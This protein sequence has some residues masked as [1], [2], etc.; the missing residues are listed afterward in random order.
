MTVEISSSPK[1]KYTNPIKNLPHPRTKHAQEENTTHNPLKQLTPLPEEN[2]DIIWN[3]VSFMFASERTALD[4]LAHK[5]TKPMGP[6]PHC[7]KCGAPTVMDGGPG[8]NRCQ[9]HPSSKQF[10]CQKCQ[11]KSSFTSTLEGRVALALLAVRDLII[12][13]WNPLT[14]RT[15]LSWAAQHVTGALA[16]P[17]TQP[18]AIIHID[19]SHRGGNVVIGLVAPDELP[20]FLIARSENSDDVTTLLRSVV[21]SK[22]DDLVVVSDGGNAIRKAVR[23]ALP[24]CVH[25]RQFHGEWRGLVAV[26]WMYEGDP[27]TLFVPWDL[28]SKEKTGMSE[29]KA[30]AAGGLLLFHGDIVY[31]SDATRM[32]GETPAHTLILT[33]AI[34]YASELLHGLSGVAEA[35]DNLAREGSNSSVFVRMFNLVVRL[36]RLLPRDERGVVL[37]LLCMVL[38]RIGEGVRPSLRR[39]GRK[40]RRAIENAGFLGGGP[41]FREAVGRAVSSL[42][43]PNLEEMRKREE[44]NRKPVSDGKRRKTPAL[45]KDKRFLLAKGSLE[46][47]ETRF[48]ELMEAPVKA[49]ETFRSLVITNNRMENLWSHLGGTRGYNL[50][51]AA[52]VRITLGIGGLIEITTTAALSSLQ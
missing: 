33:Y 52:L 18:V 46:E 44:S 4:N 31:P 13:Q 40:W 6:R 34:L 9:N 51:V 32:A 50:L 19:G 21:G 26:H 20:R 48:P 12:F 30:F 3:W 17:L 15:L 36:V 8:K 7:P 29:G 37:E 45:P 42:P 39:V 49:L 38:K 35:D 22:G 2:A 10:R 11:C 23:E 24:H 16:Q 28:L 1:T 41:A 47:L 43:A 14:S 5:F 27:L 25:I